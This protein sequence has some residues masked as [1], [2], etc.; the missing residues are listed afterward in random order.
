MNGGK[1]EGIS[2]DMIKTATDMFGK[3]TPEELNRMFQVASSFQG[4]KNGASHTFAPTPADL[5]PDMLKTATDMM[6][7]MSPK[8]LQKMFDMASSMKGN[9]ASSSSVPPNM[10]PDMIKMATD[11]MNNMPAEE[12]QKMF[13]MASSVGG[14]ERPSSTATS[15]SNG[16][17]SDEHKTRDNL[18][19]NGSDAGESSSSQHFNSTSP[20]SSSLNSS[21]D[22]QEQMRNQMK[23]PAMRQVCCLN[24]YAFYAFFFAIF[25]QLLVMQS[26]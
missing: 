10:T 14:Q 8:D 26:T 17:R 9:G 6:A 2:P 15:Y 1:V 3:M 25:L 20:Q 22:L 21:A 16:L 4:Q 5:S 7:K 11:M 19:V 13:E 23:D 18:K 12:R 24:L